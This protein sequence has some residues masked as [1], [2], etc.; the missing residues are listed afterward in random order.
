[1]GYISYHIIETSVKPAI[2]SSQSS[3]TLLLQKKAT[4]SIYY[5]TMGKKSKKTTSKSKDCYQVLGVH[6][7]ATKKTLKQAYLSLSKKYHPDKQDQEDQECIDKAKAKFQEI[8][9]AYE[10]ALA[11]L[12]SDDMYY[13]EEEDDYDYDQHMYKRGQQE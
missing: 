2:K 5:I 7:N 12:D 9:K 11:R 13:S 1:M 8:K 10:E 4:K 3:L 6:S